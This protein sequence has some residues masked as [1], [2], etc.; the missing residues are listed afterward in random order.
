MGE[1][2]ERESIIALVHL[3]STAIENSSAGEFDGD[4]FGGGICTM[5]MYG[6]SAERLLAVTLPI[7]KEF[8]APLGSYAMK[9]CGISN[10]EHRILLDG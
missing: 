8:Q 9:R 6:P 1:K 5:Y 3:L 10:D 7:L 4:E 2:E